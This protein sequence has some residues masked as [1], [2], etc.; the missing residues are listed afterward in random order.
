MDELMA[1][2]RRD[3]RAEPRATPWWPMLGRLGRRPAGRGHAP[4]RP[5]PAG[6]RADSV[7]CYPNE[8]SRVWGIERVLFDPELRS[9]MAEKGRDKLDERFGWNTVAEQVQELMG[10]TTRP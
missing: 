7:L 5:R 10:A 9:V 1:G 3:R 8:N 6:A 4:R 2:G